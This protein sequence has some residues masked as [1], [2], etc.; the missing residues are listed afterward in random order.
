M[1]DDDPQH[2]APPP[3]KTKRRILSRVR[4][5]VLLAALAL[6]AVAASAAASSALSRSSTTAPNTIEAQ[7]Q[8][9]IDDMIASGVPADS[10][11]VR[12]LQDSLDQLRS[13]DI[14]RPRRD[15]QGDVS[16]LLSGDTGAAQSRAG[17]DSASGSGDD[18]VGTAGG[19]SGDW[20]SGVIECEPIPGLLTAAEV[21]GATCVGV[22]QPDGTSRYIALGADGVARTVLF[23]AGGQVQRLP[24]TPAPA[25]LAPGAVLTPTPEGD[26]QIAPPGKQPT[27]VDVQ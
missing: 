19:A 13:P 9:E 2:K 6:S 27:V 5:S 24:D 18:A 7:L 11:K 10:P 4:G 17:V 22:P 26:L 21:A 15:P 23:G 16:G 3:P 1:S 25:G 12:M 20:D 8:S 14:G